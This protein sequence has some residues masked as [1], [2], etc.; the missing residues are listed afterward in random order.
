MLNHVF[1]ANIIAYCQQ[2]Q[3]VQFAI[4]TD[5]F[6]LRC[7]ILTLINSM[8]FECFHNKIKLGLSKKA[9]SVI[10]LHAK[11]QALSLDPQIP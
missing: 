6:T 3:H 4:Y 7:Y 5:L 9:L 10:I 1:H 8:H 2:N 11:R